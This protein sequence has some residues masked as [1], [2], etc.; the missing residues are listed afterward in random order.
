MPPKSRGKRKS[1]T[2]NQS[3]EKGQNSKGL[4]AATNLTSAGS[5]SKEQYQSQIPLELQQL[6]LN[7]FRNAFPSQFSGDGLQKLP[8]TLQEIKGHLFDRDFVKA[9]GKE[10]YLEAYAVRWSPSRALG[11]AQIV[12]ET[13][14]RLLNSVRND[15]DD[16]DGGMHAELENLGLAQQPKLGVTCLGG[17]AGAEL[18]ALGGVVQILQ[19]QMRE[20]PGD[21]ES[22]L[23]NK[24]LSMNLTLVDMASWNNVADR[25]YSALTSP[26]P[27]SE[28]ASATVKANNVALVP[29][30]SFSSSFHQA[31][32]LELSRQQLSDLVRH[33]DLIT[34]MFT[35]NEL[36]STN[37]GKTQA[38]FLNLTKVMK[39]G[40]LLLVVDSPG[41][42][43]EVK[44]NGK[45]NRYPMHWL[46]DHAL[47]RMDSKETKSGVCEDHEAKSQSAS[48]QRPRCWEKLAEV[49]S[50]WFRRPL[51]LKY[52]L[53]LE[54]MRCQIHV[55]QRVRGT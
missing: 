26:P 33:S 32:V 44:L 24:S 35:L 55:Y 40:S 8:E 48:T 2:S 12:W 45:E 17:G 16:S 31:D 18:V 46:L 51:G 53:D 9:F 37:L 41:S 14:E 4:G 54:N 42:Y 29:R 49:E 52:P 34:L 23:D 21:G 47:L 25:L 15:K 38:L 22:R 3:R 19:Q 7:V 27:L 1:G 10:E 11:Y 6:L 5:N 13:I 28:Y 39:L 20:P 43:S 36:Y 50:R 30:S